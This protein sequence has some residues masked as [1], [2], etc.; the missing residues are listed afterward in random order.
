MTLDHIGWW[1]KRE[2]NTRWHL[3]ES[4]IGLD[5]VTRCGRRLRDPGVMEQIRTH[6]TDLPLCHYCALHV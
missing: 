1:A 3:I 4:E 2:T 5:V 6:D